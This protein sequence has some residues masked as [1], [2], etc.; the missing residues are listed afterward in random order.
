MWE[1]MVLILQVLGTFMTI[2]AVIKG[3]SWVVEVGKATKPIAP[4][5]LKAI[6]NADLLLAKTLGCMSITV[7]KPVMKGA[8]LVPKAEG[9]IGK[10]RQAMLFAML[11]GLMG[12]VVI[13]WTLVE[14]A[15][16]TV[17]AQMAKLQTVA[18]LVESTRKIIAAH[19]ALRDLQQST[20][21][22]SAFRFL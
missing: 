12:L 2:I 21:T 5:V 20:R 10:V 3:G 22:G 17:L 9:T 13:P 6:V 18:M 7:M 11:V 8:I 14:I 16:I 1:T 15:K 19:R 4:A